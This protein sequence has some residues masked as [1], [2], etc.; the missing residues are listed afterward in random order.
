MWYVAA[1]ARKEVLL[2]WN[3]KAEGRPPPVPLL[4]DVFGS[5][6]RKAKTLNFSIAYGGLAASAS[7]MRERER[8]RERERGA[9]CES[10]VRAAGKTAMGL[11]RDWNV[12]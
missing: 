6:R 3:A 7:W 12:T 10:V 4:K 5:E 8:E 1:V 2:E 11:S 9:V